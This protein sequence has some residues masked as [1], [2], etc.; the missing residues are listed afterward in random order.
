MPVDGVQV[1]I[2]Q[3]YGKAWFRTED[4]RV[5]VLQSDQLITEPG[6]VVLDRNAIMNVDFGDGVSREFAGPGNVYIRWADS[7]EESDDT[8]PILDSAGIPLIER[9]TSE[10]PTEDINQPPSDGAHYLVVLRRV[11]EE[12]EG[13]RPP[14]SIQMLDSSYLSE[15]AK[16][17]LN[18]TPDPDPDPEPGPDPDPDP[19]PGPGPDPVI[20]NRPPETGDLYF[21]IP[22][23]TSIDSD[24]PGFDPDRDPL[25]YQLLTQPEHG[26]VS[27]DPTTGAFVYTPNEDYH[28]PDQFQVSV[29][30][31]R[32]EVSQTTY[33]DVTPVNDPPI[34]QDLYLTTPEDTPIPGGITASD[35]DGDTLTYTVID[36]PD[37]G[38]VSFDSTTG[39]FDYQP[40]PDYVGEDQFTVLVDDGNGGSTEAV[41]YITVTPVNDPPVA[42]DLYLTT[43]EDTPIPGGITAN[44]VDGDTLSYEVVDQP[45]FGVVEFDSITGRFTYTP[46]PDYTG[47]D[48][49][50]VSVDD[51]NGETATAHVYITVTPIQDPAVITGDDAGAVIEDSD[52]PN[53]QDTGKLDIEDPDAEEAVFDP[54]SV[55]NVTDNLGTLSLDDGG[56]WQ[57]Q[58]LNESTQYLAEGEVRTEIFSVASKDGT[59]TQVT[60]TITGVN[61]APVITVESGDSDSASLVEQDQPLRA[62]G[63][64]SANDVDVIDSDTATV[65]GV[66][67]T[68]VTGNLSASALLAMLQVNSGDVIVGGATSGSIGWTF[69]S[70]TE[71]FDFLAD[72]DRLTLDYTVELS[73]LAGEKA[74]HVVTIEIT[75]TNDTAVITGGDLGAVIEDTADPVLSFNGQLR[76]FDP[77]QGETAIAFGTVPEPEGAVLGSMSINESGAWTYQVNNADVQYLARGEA[78]LEQFW[79]TTVDGTRHP[80]KVEIFGTNDAPVISLAAGDSD[81]ASLTETDA[82]LNATGT[83]SV[84]DIDIIN[85]VTPQVVSVAQSVSTGLSRADLLAM[86]SVSPATVIGPDV[87]TGV[88]N[89][90]FSSGLESFDF[91]TEGQRLD[92]AYTVQVT[93]SAGATDT[94]EVVISL[95]GTDDVPVFTGDDNGQVTE[96]FAVDS[97]G[98]LVATGALGVDDPDAGESIFS[99]SVNDGIGNE[100]T[101]GALTISTD[102]S[103]RYSVDNAEVQ[104]LAMGET[105]TDTFI[106]FSADG[107]Q[108]TITITVN[109]TNDAPIISVGTG[110]SASANLTETDAGLSASGTLSAFDVDFSDIDSAFVIAVDVNLNGTYDEQNL[111]NMLSVNAGA[112]IGMNA[113]VGTINW[114]FDSGNQAFDILPEGVVLEL[115]YTVELRDLQGATDTQDVVIR[116]AGT[117]DPG[118]FTGGDT[119]EVKEDES[120]NAQ[121]YLSVSDQLTGYDPDA[122]ETTVNPSKT[123]ALNDVLGNL[124]IQEDGSW[125][126]VV[127]N[128]LVQYLSVGQSRIELF[129]IESGGGDTHVMAVTI[130]GT[131]DTPTLTVNSDNDDSAVAALLESDQ[132]LTAAGTLTTTDVDIRDQVTPAINSVGVTGN[133]GSL[134]TATLLSML[135]VDTTAVIANGETQGSV[136]WL[137]DSGSEEFNYLAVGERL[138]LNYTLMVD[139]AKGG[140]A[141]HQVVVTITGE[142]DPPVVYPETVQVTEGESLN[143][144]V[145][146]PTDIDSAINTSGY[147]L[148]ND[149]AAGSGALVF[150]ADGSYSF[151]TLN[152]FDYLAAGESTSVTFTYRLQDSQN[153]AGNNPVY[154]EPETVTIEITGL[155]DVPEFT[156]D[157]TGT[158]TEDN[159]PTIDSGTLVVSDLD[160]DQSAIDTS[161]SPVPVGNVLGALAI[162]AAAEWDYSVDNN[163]LQYLAEGETRADIFN[164]Y[165]IDGTEHQIT[166]TLAGVNDAPD[167]RLDS[168]D[169]AARSFNETDGI[170]STNGTLSVGDVD[171]VDSVTPSVTGVK[172]ISG[173]EGEF[174]LDGDSRLLAMMAV[175]SNAVINA[176]ATDGDIQW[177]FTTDTDDAF[178]YLA[179]GESVKVEYEITATDSQGATDTQTVTVTIKGTNDAPEVLDDSVETDEDHAVSGMVPSATDVDGEVIS[180]TTAGSVASPAGVLS[181]N[182]DGSY[183][184]D[185]TGKYDYLAEGE[186]TEFVFSYRAVDNNNDLSDFG[187]ITVV[188]NGV[189]DPGQVSTGSGTVRE[190]TTF[191]ASG[192]LSVF[193]IDNPNMAF[194]DNSY[195]D[196]YGTLTV[197]ADG[198]WSYILNQNETVDA[199]SIGQTHQQVYTIDLTD[200]GDNA[201]TNDD[202]VT[203]TVTINIQ[204]I[205][206]KPTVDDLAFTVN[207]NENLELRQLSGDDI[208]G[209][210]FGYGLITDVNEGDLSLQPNGT[211]R[212]LTNGDFDDLAEGETRD[213]TF[214]YAAADNNGAVSA[215][216]TVTITVVGIDN[217]PVIGSSFGNVVEDQSP[218][219]S[220][221]ISANDVDNPDLAFD[222]RSYSGTWG[223]LTVNANG[224]WNYTL[225]SADADPLDQGDQVTD[226]FVVDLNDGDSTASVTLNITG[227]NDAPTLDNPNISENADENNVFE[228]SLSLV[229]DVDEDD[230]YT[231]DDGNG[232]VK[233]FGYG[234]V[235]AD[236]FAPGTF[237]FNTD[238]TYTFDPRLAYDG[239]ADGETQELSFTYRAFDEQGAR[240]DIGE[241]IITLTGVTDDGPDNPNAGLIIEDNTDSVSG[242]SLDNY[243]PGAYDVDYGTLVVDG[244]GNWTFTLD[245][246]KANGSEA[247][248]IPALGPGDDITVVIPAG[249]GNDS[250][251]IEIIGTNDAPTVEDL[252]CDI[253]ETGENSVITGQLNGTDVDGNI[254]TYEVINAGDLGDST[255]V[256]NADGSFTFDPGTE[257]DHLPEGVEEN[258]SFSFQAIDNNGAVSNIGS[259]CITI[260]GEDDLP[261]LS[262]DT[263]N[264]IEDDPASNSS[265]GVIVFDDVDD[266][267]STD[268]SVTFVEQNVVG[269]YGTFTLD[270][271]GNWN[272]TLDN[273]DADT[274]SLNV[275]EQVTEEFTVETTNGATSNVTV[276][277]TGA[278]DVPVID[279]SDNNISAT[280]DEDTALIGDLPQATDVDSLG[281]IVGYVQRGDLVYVSDDTSAPGELI[282]YSDGTYQ[283]DPRGSYDYLADGETTQVAFNFA[284]VDNDSG[285]S[286]EQ[287]VTITIVGV[288]D[289]PEISTAN[290][291]VTE[292]DVNPAASGQLTAS[293]PDDDATD[294]SFI[295]ATIDGEYGTLTLDSDGNWEYNLGPNA[296]TLNNGDDEA[297]VFT[298]NLSDG[299]TTTVTVNVEGINDVPTSDDVVVTVDEDSVLNTSIPAAVDV[300]GTVIGYRLVDGSFSGPGNLSFSSDGTFTY[301]P[302]DN[303][304]QLDAG[305]TEAVTFTYIMQDNSDGIS[306]PVTVTINVTGFNDAPTSTAIDSQSSGEGE[307]ISLDV[308][309]SFDDI[310]ADNVFTYSATGLPSSLSIDSQTGLISGTIDADAGTD[311][312][313][314]VTV[315]ATDS[316]GEQTSQTFIWTVTNPAPD[317]VNETSGNDDDNYAFEV[318]EDDAVGTAVGTVSAQDPDND[319]LTYTITSGNAAGLFA[320]DAATGAITLAQS[321]GDV[322]VGDYSLQVLVDD[323]EGGTDSATV[324][325]SVNNINDAPVT[326]S[327][328]ISV[329]EDSTNNS[330]GLTAPTDV[331]GD[332][333]T[334]TVTELPSVG[335]VTLANG[336]PVAAGA[337]LTAAQLTGLLYNAPE[338]LAAEQE[339]TFAYQVDDGQGEANS[340]ASG[341]VVISLSPVNDA[342][343]V[344]SVDLGAVDED[345]SISF[346]EADLLVGSDDEE[347]DIL[348]VQDLTI[349]SGAGTLVEDSPGSWTYTPA[350]NDDTEVAFSFGVSD[351]ENAA[352]SNTASLDITPINDAPEL[353]GDLSAEVEE[354]GRYTLTTDD[355]YYQDPDNTQAD[356]AFTVQNLANGVI[357]VDGVSATSFSATELAAGQVVFVLDGGMFTEASFDVSVEDNNDD[358]SAPV[359]QT[360]TFTVVAAE[361]LMAGADL[362]SGPMANTF[363]AGDT[364]GPEKLG[365]GD[366]LEDTG[367]DWLATAFS[368]NSGNDTS[369]YEPPA[370]AAGAPSGGGWVGG[371]G[372]DNPFEQGASSIDL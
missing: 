315:T 309:G 54:A 97:A 116:I 71:V 279:A 149:I 237:I 265:S 27:L 234:L 346:D 199:L 348:S 358:V 12:L 259:G 274:N 347:G 63:T 190:D 56:N 294:L 64:L 281:R 231:D 36:D 342:P 271:S 257:Y 206:D 70:G 87:T 280:I 29:S 173:N 83:L 49:F 146:A 23:D 129:Q 222:A 172:V 140:Q 101:S 185:P 304:Q 202:N 105:L 224:S 179:V 177:V 198:S 218:T 325:I 354:G 133:A 219:A 333:L 251:T 44:D 65:K 211:F 57:Y 94:H 278:N 92:L 290:V 88:L 32:T 106:V 103:W 132:P 242:G 193:D 282:F 227:T 55:L 208:D 165:S 171:I 353:T 3:V 204:G 163:L 341:E 221:T 228:G 168:G 264:V 1:E 371:G 169:Q 118:I 14:V 277:I 215:P 246:D 79:I 360:F 197:N 268:G 241:V 321:P 260:V 299:S 159:L 308:S 296:Q 135:S 52:D 50:T 188:I 327:S 328:A 317:F 148:V 93:D 125:E 286:N 331:D 293:D 355:L 108:H 249:G 288:D 6:R 256:I 361:P 291:N 191:E 322:E 112:V 40:G 109:G 4:G 61:D 39:T 200:G 53:L 301:D 102:G 15:Q 144:Q 96:D 349:S 283:F 19:D 339:V 164:V 310:D 207:E 269:V 31:G 51:G 130:Q 305:D 128:A 229:S 313:F 43:P 216:G 156:G 181:F 66:E 194:V 351:G 166:V 42:Q 141:Q 26:T 323:G 41:V 145:P 69:D 121:G 336:T 192:K 21:T 359:P 155:N 276:S 235:E 226:S 76:G 312:P 220:G 238:G 254:V 307:Q 184:V 134:S 25:T 210:I 335:Q 318:N 345:A 357:E 187:Q 352:V 239:L 213:V 22:E 272:Y 350:A 75:G 30:D 47:D 20:P 205:N 245:P 362:S 24:I 255:L 240:S 37:N 13:L 252:E 314:S 45:E 324:S 368:E 189:D 366:L 287:T 364:S 236:D 136:N 203:T 74:E 289:A 151:D 107:S 150:N 292:D 48:Q 123:V 369:G 100:T 89:W 59:R 212:F 86:L 170:R 326:A 372:L 363:M 7:T 343:T 115:T 365:L 91:L 11:G 225:R 78:R 157:D 138:V 67:A 217:A 316:G 18:D 182:S 230:G 34:A 90:N 120:V 196:E 329:N 147:E 158:V 38:T 319:P 175:N 186:S 174:E 247:P 85:S 72:G 262:N 81:S 195:S 8:P 180:Y 143:D 5:I 162:T 68:G 344:N 270:A 154:S 334:I 248:S 263:G 337:V 214:E 311:S 178:D 370:P 122:G 58:V 338:T 9:N 232:I 117:A 60:V 243:T 17:V 16:H 160:A 340:Q 152:D 80:I 35:L 33:I 113:D 161:R 201:T 298:I 183:T 104:Y 126:Y 306:D 285:V 62:G 153:D 98:K 302:G 250:V 124:T 82:E 99:S 303:F 2:K 142:N 46:G 267:E 356:I 261:S 275:D 273:A 10:Q 127:D 84:N 223:D 367:D 233:G 110:N 176:G 244:D 114:G 77:D 73:D 253:V 330:L 258:F 320:L 167:I 28:G 137:F 284:A 131:N 119:G 95:T 297:D 111:L 300:D 209:S 266:G 139:D 332:A 295:P